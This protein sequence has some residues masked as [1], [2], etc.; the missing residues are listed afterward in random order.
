MPNLFFTADTHLNHTNI[1]KY[2][3][4]PFSSTQEMNDTIITNWNA[5]VRPGD[6]IYH[7]GD[8]G[9]GGNCQQI[10][11]RLNGNKFILK[12]NHDRSEVFGYGWGW[13]KDVYVLK[14]EGKI[15]WLSHYPHRSWPHS[16]HGSWHLFGHVHGR[17]APYGLSLD[18]GVDANRF[19]PVSFDDL[20][21][22]MDK[23]NQAGQNNDESG[24]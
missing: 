15:I 2:C 6:S 3:N 1:I 22:K 12:G 5:V 14:H 23:L 21:V 20:L 9:F 19:A 8:F 18:V 10:F 24:V 4:R 13:V 11:K 17:M 16:F 7:L